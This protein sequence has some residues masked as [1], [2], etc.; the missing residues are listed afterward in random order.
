M[1]KTPEAIMADWELHA[2]RA[3]LKDK[4]LAQAA[5]VSATTVCR[6]KTQVDTSSPRGK[7]VF[8]VA[9][10]I[11]ER[12]AIH[13][14]CDTLDLP[15][16]VDASLGAIRLSLRQFRRQADRQSAIPTVLNGLA[17]YAWY[18]MQLPRDYRSQ[19]CQLVLLTY[20]DIACRW[21]P[22]PSSSIEEIL[23]ESL[24]MIE[25]LMQAGLETLV[26]CVPDSGMAEEYKTAGFSLPQIKEV[27]RGR[28]LS[29]G[30]FASSMLDRLDDDCNDYAMQ[31]MLTALASPRMDDDMFE[32]NVLDAIEQRF[33][34][35]NKDRAIELATMA[36]E[37][38]LLRQRVVPALMATKVHLKVPLDSIFTWM[39]RQGYS[40]PTEGD[41]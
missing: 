28:L 34:S 2:D 40:V 27:V 21:N 26:A 35:G 39:L 32:L 19:A 5:G 1:K 10:M 29:Q 8:R 25:D 14:L 31:Q 9:S 12:E 38:E 36:F 3:G 41:E 22:D 17:Q 7:R 30:G 37:S 11:V 6:V 20:G 24:R 16:A 13:P 33:W 4:D 23:D 15:S 18:V